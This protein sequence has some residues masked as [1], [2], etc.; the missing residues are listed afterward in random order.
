MNRLENVNRI[1]LLGETLV[2]L[3]S[4]TYN[5]K[6]SILY[7]DGKNRTELMWF[8]IIPADPL[9]GLFLD[10]INV[11]FDDEAECIEDNGFLT[12]F[13]DA[14]NEMQRNNEDSEDFVYF[15]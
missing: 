1:E 6:A 2:Q 13:M 14:L 11:A 8:Q 10:Q 3:D 4:T 15:I 12:G 9:V 5:V 7:T